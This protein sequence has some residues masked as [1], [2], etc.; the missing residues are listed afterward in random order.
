M[1]ETCCTRLAENT[2]RKKSPKNRH[3][4]TIAQLCQLRH[5]SAIGKNCLSSNISST[6]P[7]NMVNFGPL[8][9]E[10]CPV[11]W[12]TPANFNG[13]RVLASL[14]QRRRS[15]EANQTLYDV[16]PLHGLV[17]YIY[18]FGGCC[19][20]TEFCQVQ[21]SLCIL[22]VL[23]CPIGS[24]TARHSSSGREPNFAALSTG[25]HLYSAGRPSRWALAHIL[26]DGSLCVLYIVDSVQHTLCVKLQI[27][28][29][30]ELFN[31]ITRDR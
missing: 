11:V 2:G 25:R 27:I 16:W 14:L 30:S 19:R 3:L 24:V 20:V 5:V 10:I 29:I 4:G 22:Q 13:F 7:H 23:R 8:A 17:D 28:F 31:S 26:V 6:C 9:D 12:G 1:S 21:N 18:T 15:T